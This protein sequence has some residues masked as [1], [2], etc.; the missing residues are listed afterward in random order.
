MLQRFTHESVLNTSKTCLEFSQPQHIEKIFTQHQRLFLL[1]IQQASESEFQK[2]SQWSISKCLGDHSGTNILRGLYSTHK[3]FTNAKNYVFIAF[4]LHLIPQQ[5]RKWD[6]RNKIV[7]CTVQT[8]STPNQGSWPMAP[9][10]IKHAA[11]SVGGSV[12][13]T[14]WTPVLSVRSGNIHCMW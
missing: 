6:P 8:C 10:F 1:L 14:R 3:I 5:S 12:S 2:V 13:D 7:F 4:L 11:A 9:G